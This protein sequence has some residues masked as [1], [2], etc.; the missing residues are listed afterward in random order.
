MGEAVAR[1]FETEHGMNIRR[2]GGLSSYRD[3]ATASIPTATAMD[4]NVSRMRF[5]SSNYFQ[6]DKAADPSSKKRSGR[7][8]ALPNRYHFVTP[9]RLGSRLRRS[10][11]RHH[12][13]FDVNFP[14]DSAIG[15]STTSTETCFATNTRWTSSERT[16]RHP[17]ARATIL[18]RNDREFLPPPFFVGG[19]SGRRRFLLLLLLVV[20]KVLAGVRDEGVVGDAA[21]LGLDP[22]LQG[23]LRV[24]GDQNEPKVAAWTCGGHSILLL[25]LLYKYCNRKGGWV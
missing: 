16:H 11:R 1:D 4:L 8:D 19:E 7:A 9:F 6:C 22:L 23:L 3:S 18:V 17:P 15:R 13:F 24:G 12:L 5:V 25:L 20:G 2:V 14:A 10:G 21:G